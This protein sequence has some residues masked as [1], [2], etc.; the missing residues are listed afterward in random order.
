MIEFF[1]F[2]ISSSFA[3]SVFEGVVGSGGGLK[4]GGSVGGMFG[5]AVEGDWEFGGVFGRECAEGVTGVLG[6]E[7]LTEIVECK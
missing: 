3:I 1:F 6:S 4:F 7:L 2:S 5:G